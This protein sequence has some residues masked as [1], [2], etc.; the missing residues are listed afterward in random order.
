MLPFDKIPEAEG[1]ISDN[2][3]AVTLISVFSLIAIWIT[4]KNT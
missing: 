3:L 2:L 1:F 4:R